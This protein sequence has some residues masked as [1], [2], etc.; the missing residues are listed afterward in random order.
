[1]CHRDQIVASAVTTLSWIEIQHWSFSY[2]CHVKCQTHLMEEHNNRSILTP[3]TGT[4]ELISG[5]WIG[6]SSIE[7]SFAGTLTFLLLNSCGWRRCHM[8]N[9]L[10]G[11]FVDSMIVVE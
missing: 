11:F 3:E 1:M 9:L 4:V 10:F 6:H 2:R 5:S 7:S 8:N